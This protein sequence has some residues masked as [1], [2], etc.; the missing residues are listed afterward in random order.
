LSNLFKIICT[1]IATFVG[2]G[3]AS[4][5]EIYLY[6]FRYG[7]YGFLG[8]FLSSIFL[9]FIIYKSML[10]IKK[11]NI[12]NYND[13]L[14]IIIKNKI[15][16]K[17][18]KKLINYYLLL[19]FCIMINGFCNLIKQE[20]NINIYFS[21]IYIFFICLYCYFKNIKIFLKINTFLIPIIFFSI[22]FFL[23]FNFK[24]INL[25]NNIY[26]KNNFFNNY[27]F[28]FIIYA[29]YN[30]LSIIPVITIITKYLK[31]KKLVKISS[32]F[33]AI[34][35]FLLS[36]SIFF[37]L[38]NGDVYCWNQDMPLISIFKKL[39]NNYLFIYFFIILFSIITTAISLGYSYI[40]KNNKKIHLLLLFIT[41]L[42]LI[43]FSFSDLIKFLY[44]ICGFFGIMQSYYIVKNRNKN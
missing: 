42:L 27:F 35:I 4:G 28:S 34:I 15:I 37:I 40:N 16:K 19:S 31:N 41:S 39:N 20:F 25:K 33:F 7:K 8:I 36:I 26:E 17:I 43:N 24:N 38:Q 6:F 14:E 5:K 21:Y 23:F 30:L 13:F 2:A 11:N 10:I 22:L 32:I 29:N 1:I 12:N 44:P 9:G 3:F 18:F